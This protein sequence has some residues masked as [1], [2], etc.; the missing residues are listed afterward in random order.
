[1]FFFLREGQFSRN[2]VRYDWISETISTFEPVTIIL[3][4]KKK[5]TCTCKYNSK[6]EILGEI[7]IVLHS[8]SG[9]DST[10]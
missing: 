7:F 2:L 1:M 6:F 9:I 4:E 10:F 8:D 5:T 3:E